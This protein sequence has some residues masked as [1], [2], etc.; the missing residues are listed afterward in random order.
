MKFLYFFKKLYVKYS[1]SYFDFT[2]FFQLS[3]N[4]KPAILISEAFDHDEK[5]L[6]GQL[7]DQIC[8]LSI[9]KKVTLHFSQKKSRYKNIF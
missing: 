3:P 4:E 1:I 6:S 2:L 7:S 5:C 9:G 8:V